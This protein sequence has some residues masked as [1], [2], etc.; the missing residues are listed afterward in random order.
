MFKRINTGRC[1]GEEL[2]LYLDPERVITKLAVILDG[3]QFLSE[4]DELESERLSEGSSEYGKTAY[5]LAGGKE[6]LRLYTPWGS[7]AMNERFPDFGGCGKE[8]ALALAQELPK[9]ERLIFEER[10]ASDSSVN[11]TQLERILAGFSLGGLEAVYA[12]TVTDAF[13]TIIS[14]SGSFW[15]PDWE[16]FIESSKPLRSETRFLLFCGKAEGS[17]KGNRQASQ[18]LM[19]QRTCQWLSRFSEDVSFFPDEKGHHDGRKIRAEKALWL[20]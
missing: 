7:K 18:F 9:I 16:N 8:F 2:V 12:S 17:G 10:S 13:D 14:M 5:L 19:N 20:I 4:I 3:E 15:Y 11:N 1:M 6:R